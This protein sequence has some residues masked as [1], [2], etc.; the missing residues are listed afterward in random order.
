MLS[1]ELGGGEKLRLVS[2]EDVAN[3][4]RSAPWS[5]TDT[6]DQQTT[7]RIGTALNSDLL[8]LG[9]YATIGRRD[10]GQMRLDVGL[11]DAQTGEILT[12]IAEIGGRQELFR[13]VF[14]GG[15]EVRV[16]R[17]GPRLGE[18]GHNTGLASLPANAEAARFYS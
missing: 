15:G 3:L 4:R 12:E 11:Q 2:G 14:R 9:S 17:G 7:A 18:A 16:R 10:R 5:Q 13:V 8:V 1:T 6:L